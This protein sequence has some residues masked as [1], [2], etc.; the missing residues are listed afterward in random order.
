[1]VAKDMHISFTVGLQKLGALSRRKFYPQEIDNFLNQA[2]DNFVKSAVKEDKEGDYFHRVQADVDKV[3]TLLVHDY[4][5]DANQ[6][7]STRQGLRKASLPLPSNYAY[8]ISDAAGMICTEDISATISSTEY[9]VPI[10]YTVT[11]KVSPK[12][13]AI[14]TIQSVL[15]LVA[16]SLVALVADTQQNL[17]A[18]L[19]IGYD[20]VTDW[21]FG[22]QL[23]WEVFQEKKRAGLNV[24]FDLY[25][26]RFGNIYKPNNF[27]LIVPT[28]G[29]TGRLITD[30]T[31]TNYTNLNI[32][33][34]RVT[35]TVSPSYYPSRLTKAD[36]IDNVLTTPY[37][38]PLKTSPISLI[39]D[40]QLIVYT[41]E[42]YIVS[43][44]SLTYIR[45]PA[46]IDVTLQRNCELPE[47]F[48]QYIVDKAI[49]YAAGK[50]EQTPLVQL[51]KDINDQTK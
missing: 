22:K 3:K 24:G 36:S 10:P 45:K 4:I 51:Q 25:W 26:E 47:E 13:Y 30:S 35:S 6:E 37:Y 38:K 2:M 11:T 42:S 43:K 46:K 8:L 48:H 31:T 50:L 20:A 28:I 40:E 27:I 5:L 41:P 18:P 17:S 14:S 34:T 32:S 12:Y 19:Y 29:H 21:I 49:E 44:I 16:T 39:S 33:R 23:I 15:S 7:T 1:M 9:Y